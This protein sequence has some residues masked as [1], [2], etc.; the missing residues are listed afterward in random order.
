M[1]KQSNGT[2]VPLINR[3]Y[4]CRKNYSQ[5]LR[6]I[7]N[8]LNSA[9]IQAVMMPGKTLGEG[10]NFLQECQRMNC[11]LK[12][13]LMIMVVNHDNLCKKAMRLVFAFLFAIIIIF[14]V[15]SAQY[16]SFRIP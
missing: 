2:M 14:F 15:L 6:L 4:R 7:S 1:L 12:D 8:N 3:S 16:E 10:L 5:M 11:Y 9:T 13:L